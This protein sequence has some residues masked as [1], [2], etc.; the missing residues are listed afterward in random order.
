MTEVCSGCRCGAGFTPPEAQ[1]GTPLTPAADVYQFGGL[2]Y[3]MAMGSYPPTPLPAHG[4]PTG[5]QHMPVH[6]Y[7]HMHMLL[8]S[9]ARLWLAQHKAPKRQVYSIAVFVCMVIRD[10][11]SVCSCTEF[12]EQKGATGTESWLAAAIDLGSANFATWVIAWDNQWLCEH[13]TDVVEYTRCIMLNACCMVACS[14]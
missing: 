3:F 5:T 2:C 11:H 13:D 1:E 12:M 14:G 8:L 4:S 10:M 9:V 7:C 6:T